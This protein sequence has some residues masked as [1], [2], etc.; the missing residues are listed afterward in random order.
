VNA[1]TKSKPIVLMDDVYRA[2]KAAEAARQKA[3]ADLVKA[4]KRESKR[5]ARRRSK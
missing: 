2:A 4:V 1:A 5:A 3:H